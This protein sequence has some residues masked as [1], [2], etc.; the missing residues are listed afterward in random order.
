MDNKATIATREAKRNRTNRNETNEIFHLVSTSFSTFSYPYFP[1]RF[2]TNTCTGVPSTKKGWKRGVGREGGHPKHQHFASATPT[3]G[4]GGT[5]GS[6]IRIKIRIRIRNGR[7]ESTGAQSVSQ[8][9]S[10]SEQRTGWNFRLKQ[11]II[12]F[13]YFIPKT[14]SSERV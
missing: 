10:K 4:G 12:F 11:M 9:K 1:Q 2:G 5:N 13:D 6:R 8:S 7:Q 14:P 3:G